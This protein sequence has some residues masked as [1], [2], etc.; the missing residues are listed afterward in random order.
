M[1]IVGVIILATVLFIAAVNLV[2]ACICLILAN[3]TK[4]I[5]SEYR[6]RRKVVRTLYAKDWDRI[7]EMTKLEKAGRKK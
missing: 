6:P 7:A 4:R 1:G 3:P 5:A 2:L